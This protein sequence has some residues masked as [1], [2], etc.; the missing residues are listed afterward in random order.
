MS[1]STICH[2]EHWLATKLAILKYTPK[3]LYPTILLVGLH[4]CVLTFFA[5]AFALNW[6]Q[7]PN[8]M[9]NSLFHD[10]T[11]RRFFKETHSGFFFLILIVHVAI[12]EWGSSV[13]ASKSKIGEADDFSTETW[14]L[15]MLPHLL[16]LSGR[17]KRKIIWNW[18]P[19]QRFLYTLF[20]SLRLL[21][22]SN[23]STA[24]TDQTQSIST[25]TK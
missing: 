6:V 13:Y 1:P 8:H 25:L 3:C 17:K 20:M 18:N 21:L 9:R 14:K 23:W 4:Q 24:G 16:E 12:V 15:P 10:I 5:F 7:R 19:L 11:T 22:Q 2:G